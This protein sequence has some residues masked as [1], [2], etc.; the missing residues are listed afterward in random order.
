MLGNG[1]GAIGANVCDHNT[2][3]G[4]GSQVYI[5][6][7]CRQQTDEANFRTGLEYAAGQTNLVANYDCSIAGA[8]RDVVGFGVTENLEIGQKARTHRIPVK[9]NC[10]HVDIR[11]K[12]SQSTGR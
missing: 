11:S 12:V 1:L 10:F 8:R 5:V 2:V 3:I 9:E 4:S 7:A 6:R